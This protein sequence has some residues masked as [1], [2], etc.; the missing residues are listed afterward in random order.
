MAGQ[1][2]NSTKAFHPLKRHSNFQTTTAKGSH[3]KVVL[4]VACDIWVTLSSHTCNSSRDQEAVFSPTISHQKKIR[5]IQ[6]K[7]ALAI[8]ISNM[9]V[10]SKLGPEIWLNIVH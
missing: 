2:L 8:S 4:P 9:A 3:P 5:E 7:K 1:Q 6:K 10:F